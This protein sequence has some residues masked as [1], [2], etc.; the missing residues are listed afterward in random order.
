MHG[1]P[2]AAVA[3]LDV[4]DADG[5]LVPHTGWTVTAD[6]EELVGE[7]AAA[8]RAIDGDAN[9]F[10][11]TRWQGANPAGPHRLTVDLG[12]PKTI[13]GFRYLPRQV[14]E[15][16]RIADW[17]LQVSSDGATWSEAAS[18]T[19]ANAA[20]PVTILFVGSAGNQPPVISPLPDRSDQIGRA[21]ALR[22]VASDG[23]GD[24]IGYSVSGLPPGLAIDA[25][26]GAISGVPASTGSFTVQA[27]ASDGKGGVATTGFVW[28]VVASVSGGSPTARYVR[29]EAVS[30]VH[31]NPWT[32]IAELDILDD[33]GSPLPRTGWTASADSEERVGENAPAA[34]AIDGDPKSFWHTRW[35]GGSPAGPHALTIDLGA[36]QRVGGFRYLPR[37]VGENGRIAH[38]RFYTSTNGSDWSLASEGNFDN[39]AS[40]STVTIAGTSAPTA[41][42]APVGP[43]PNLPPVLSS[44]ADRSDVLGRAVA[45]ALVASDP[46][47]DPL[48]FSATG[49]PSGVTIDANSGSMSGTPT[50]AGGFAVDVQ[51][52]DG[53]GGTARASFG[54][55]IVAA[56]AGNGA[57]AVR[58]SRIAA[59]ASGPLVAGPRWRAS[60]A[61][62][63]DTVRRLASGHHLV[64]TA[65][66]TTG[67]TEPVFGSTVI[68][69]RP[70]TDG[71]ATA[72]AN[73]RVLSASRSDA[74]TVTAVANAA[75]AGLIETGFAVGDFRAP[76]YSAVQGCRSLGTGTSFIG[77]YCHA[78]GTAAASGNA[79]A[80]ASGPYGAGLSPDYAYHANSWAEEFIV[81]DQYFGLVFAN[82]ASAIDVEIDGVQVEAAP[83][84]S[85]GREGWTMTFDYH[86]AV[87]RRTVRVVSAAGSVAPVLRGVALTT[88]GRVEAGTTSTDQVLILG[89]SINATVTPATEAGTQMMSYWVERYLGFGASINMAVGG[90]GYVSANPNTFNLP[91]L[92]ANPVNR[93]L[94]ASYAPN[95]THVIVGAGFNDRSRPVA[96][97]AAAALASWKALRVLLP[98]VRI[99]ITDGWSGSGGPDEQSLALAAALSSTFAAWGD[100]DARLI[101]SIGTSASTAYVNGTGHAGAPITAGNSSMYTSTDAVHPSPAGA[102][103]LARRL[104]D[105]IAA[106]WAGAY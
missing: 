56:P 78:N 85:S 87:K 23:D 8:I 92:L 6:S 3:E 80:V 25:A 74:P 100:P 95:I 43:G 17:R 51:V 67:S 83:T 50:A 11:H 99:S 37:Q 70:V 20:L 102:R 1:N 91:A 9:S 28:T 52:G 65:A 68:D 35:Q 26:T 60:E 4:L 59:F 76:V 66:G 88:Q 16:G 38:W 33:D 13:S 73:G 32:S 44:P 29:L 40:E 61:V 63:V 39:V 36:F 10:W 54:W 105:D 96:E 42:I 31:G 14:G 77:H 46:D 82:S 94:I 72:Y 18:G 75:A 103:Y 19:F 49:L 12:S 93:S 101:R 89:D 2:W 79:T 97:V 27:Q 53:K 104:A 84:I 48:T 21:V 7:N 15:N 106:A 69:G 47:G 24:P 64:Y 55:T 81:T 90:S 45:Q 62:A 86:G 58:E 41:P 71:T 30:E 22:L 34:L 98:H 57:N 5:A